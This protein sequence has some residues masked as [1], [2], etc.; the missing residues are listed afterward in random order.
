MSSLLYSV[1]TFMLYMVLPCWW[2][3]NHCYC[4]MIIIAQVAQVR[5]HKCLLYRCMGKSAQLFVARWEWQYFSQCDKLD[6]AY[7][8]YIALSMH[9]FCAGNLAE[10]DYS[11]LYIVALLQTFN[12]IIQPTSTITAKL[13]MHCMFSLTCTWPEIWIF[14]NAPGLLIRHYRPNSISKTPSQN[15]L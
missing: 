4:A 14:F 3:D 10:T 8:T 9:T 5:W 12:I 7:I 6:C 11:A 13:I 2:N 15:L 1:S